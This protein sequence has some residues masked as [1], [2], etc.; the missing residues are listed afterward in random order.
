MEALRKFEK[1]N[2]EENRIEYS[3]KKKKAEREIKRNS[4]RKSRKNL[5]QNQTK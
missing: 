2:R 4:N 3:A 5:E 1:T